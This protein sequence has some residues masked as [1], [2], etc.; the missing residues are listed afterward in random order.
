MATLTTGMFLLFTC[1]HFWVCVALRRWSTCVPTAYQVVWGCRK[2]EKYW[3][4]MQYIV[5]QYNIVQYIIVQYIIIQYII[6]QYIIIQ[7]IRIPL[8]AWMFVCCVYMLCCP[9]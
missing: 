3:C 9:V 5:V 7:Y 4:K 8:G 2:F 1:V 6:V